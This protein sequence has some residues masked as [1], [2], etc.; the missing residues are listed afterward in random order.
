MK[1]AVL[2]CLVI[3][4]SVFAAESKSKSKVNDLGFTKEQHMAAEASCKAINAEMR[5]RELKE[6]IKQKLGLVSQ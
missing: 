3:S 1:M 5:G 6:C 4:G 2:V